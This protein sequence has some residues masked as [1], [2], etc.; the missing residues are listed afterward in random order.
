METKLERNGSRHFLDERLRQA[1]VAIRLTHPTILF[2]GR[3]TLRVL[4]RKSVADDLV[5][6]RVFAAGDIFS[7]HGAFIARTSDIS[8]LHQQPVS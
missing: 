1:S 4:V 5:G 3:V 2:T 8:V 6:F 7:V